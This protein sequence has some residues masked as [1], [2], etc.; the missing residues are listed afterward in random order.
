MTLE[1][2]SSEEG[3]LEHRYDPEK[4]WTLQ[5][6]LEETPLVLFD[7]TI[8]TRYDGWCQFLLPLLKGGRKRSDLPFSS[9]PVHLQNNALYL[10]RLSALLD[11]TRGRWAMSEEVVDELRRHVDAFLTVRHTFDCTDTVLRQETLNGLD[12]Y[13]HAYSTFLRTLDGSVIPK[14]RKN[15]PVYILLDVLDARLDLCLPRRNP[16]EDRGLFN[17]QEGA[18]L[19]LVT[20]AI[21]AAE[22]NSCVGIVSN[23]ADIHRLLMA[24]GRYMMRQCGSKQQMYAVLGGHIDRFYMFSDEKLRLSISTACCRNPLSEDV[25]PKARAAAR[26]LIARAYARE[27]HASPTQEI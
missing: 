24:F 8:T 16:L 13:L 10:K 2:S 11:E 7:T 21:R 22:K 6:I 1:E 17:E 5:E 27:Q 20:A 19:G 4:R 12:E 14:Q 9:L 15:D 3:M 18:D 25:T 26:L 23:D